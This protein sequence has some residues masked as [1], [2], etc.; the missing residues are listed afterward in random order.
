MVVF[1]F[2]NMFSNQSINLL[3][4]LCLQAGV[5]GGEIKCGISK[6]ILSEAKKINPNTKIDRYGNVISTLGGGQNKIIIDA[7]LDE[8]GFTIKKMNQR[9]F[10]LPQGNCD[11]KA[12]NKKNIK[13]VGK[14]INGK[15]NL[16]QNKIL[17][18]LPFDNKQSEQISTGDFAI[19]QKKFKIEGKNRIKSTALDNRVGCFVLLQI[20]KNL[21]KKIPSNNSVTFVFSA[22]EEIGKFYLNKVLPKT[23]ESSI[24]IVDAAYAQPITFPKKT[25]LISIPISGKGCAVQTRGKNFFIK[26]ETIENI[27]KLAKEIGIKTQIETPPKNEGKTSLSGLKSKKFKQSIILNIPVKNQHTEL[28]ECCL[29]DVEGAIKIIQTLAEKMI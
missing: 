6:F 17:E 9:F 18:F 4:K 8:F 23:K 22:G 14:K 21:S 26:K 25:D 3:K 2:L 12:I 11:Y 28:S 1:I 15:I 7:H 19:F 5:S 13:L 29:D 24:I 10:L 16:I 27:K 20:L